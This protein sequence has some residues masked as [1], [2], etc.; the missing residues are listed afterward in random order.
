MDVRWFPPISHFFM[1]SLKDFFFFQAVD[2]HGARSCIITFLIVLPGF[3]SSQV[4]M[5][6]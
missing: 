5:S 4:R 1:I 6:L 2:N 3:N